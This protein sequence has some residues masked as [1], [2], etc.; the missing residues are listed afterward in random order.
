MKKEFQKLRDE[1]L[2]AELGEGDY[3]KTK[4]FGVDIEVYVSDIE[5]PSNGYA[6]SIYIS[7]KDYGTIYVILTNDDEEFLWEHCSFDGSELFRLYLLTAKLGGYE[8]L[9][10][11]L[12][13]ENVKE[14]E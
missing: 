8:E 3:L 4:M 11:L 9:D 6:Y 7:V 5:Y 14:A 10:K 1:I 13:D 12:N 2:R